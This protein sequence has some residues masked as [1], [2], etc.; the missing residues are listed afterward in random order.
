MSRPGEYL[1]DALIEDGIDVV[2]IYN[3]EGS[4][5]KAAK[6]LGVARHTLRNWLIKKGLNKP[7]GRPR[8]GV[9]N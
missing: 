5:L 3:K 9:V 2:E 8:K 6:R 1:C 4:V 7:K